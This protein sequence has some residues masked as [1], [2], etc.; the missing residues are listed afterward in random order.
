VRDH[1][2]T[3]KANTMARDKSGTLLQLAPVT[4]PALRL[5]K[6]SRASRQQMFNH[7]LSIHSCSVVEDFQCVR[8]A[9][10]C[11]TD[12]DCSIE[13]GLLEPHHGDGIKGVLHAFA[14]CV[15]RFSIEARPH[16][17]P[18]DPILVEAKP[19]LLNKLVPGI[20]CWADLRGVDELPRKRPPCAREKAMAIVKLPPDPQNSF[21]D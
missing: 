3:K 5:H 2:A 19:P 21:M 14:K 4:R 9:G 11:I 7:N 13:R 18:H 10:V 8:A 1:K 17:Q 15:E 16:E 20:G 6:R 12:Y